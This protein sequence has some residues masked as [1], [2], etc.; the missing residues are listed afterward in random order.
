[1]LQIRSEQMEA[2]QDAAL[3]AF[4]DEMVEHSKEFSPRLSAVLGDDQ[5]RL[6]VRSAIQ[7]SAAYGFTFRGSIRLF[8]E[9]MFL[10]G[11]GFDSDPQY[12]WAAK[13]LGSN[14]DQME[15]AEDLCKATL[16]YQKHVSGPEAANTRKALRE[17]AVRARK[18]PTF[19]S[20]TFVSGVLS[21]IRHVFPQKADYIGETQLISMINESVV[22]ARNCQLPSTRGEALIA[23]LMF[24]FGHGCIRDPLYPWIHRTLNDE[25]IVNSSARTD[26]LQRKAILWLD[27]VVARQPE[28]GAQ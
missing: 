3:A 10:F 2:F 11:S 1:M 21:E 14:T 13:I 16:D 26:R 20:E 23:V 19:A 4:E 7:R 5:L 24:A 22:E 8:I 25:R 6:A 12:P 9:L 15:R 28:G 18:P 17:L 27:H